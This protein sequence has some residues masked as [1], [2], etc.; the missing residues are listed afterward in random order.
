[1]AQVA[2]PH[3]APAAERSSNQKAC[4]ACGEQINV[5]AEVCPKCG[6]RQRRPVSKPVLLLITFFLG[7][8]GAHKFYL[9]KPWQGVLYLLFCWTMIP[10]I[11]KSW[12]GRPGVLIAPPKT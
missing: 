8:L 3:A 12:Y 5:R 7:G 1:M 10:G 4:D 6:V 11:R 9:G 2:I